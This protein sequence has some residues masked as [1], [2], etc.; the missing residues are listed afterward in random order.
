MKVLYKTISLGGRE[1]SQIMH[2]ICERVIMHGICERV[3]VE[4]ES[5]SPP[6]YIVVGGVEGSEIS[7]H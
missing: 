1:E 5:T 6:P 4:L 3:G 7:A 2:G